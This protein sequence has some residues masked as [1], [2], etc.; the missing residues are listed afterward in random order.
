[1]RWI[2]CLITPLLALMATSSPADDGAVPL[3]KEGRA[4]ATVALPPEPTATLRTAAEEIVAYVAKISGVRLPIGGG[5][6][7]GPRIVLEVAPQT[8]PEEDAFR[9][10]TRPDEVRLLGG[11]EAGVLYAAYALLEDLGVRW[12]APGREG[13]VVPTRRSVAYPRTDR[14]ETPGFRC[15]FFYVESPETLLWAVRN[16]LNG[17]FPAKFAAAHG[18]SYYLPPVTPS[19]HSLA[20]LL[21]PEKY[22]A[23]HPEYYAL[24]GG[25]RAPC[26]E[27]HNQ[28]C[29]S[30]PQVIEIIA[31]AIRRHF[32]GTPG[33]R[34]Y[35][36]APN[37]GYGWCEC[38]RCTALD[39]KLCHSKKWW[40]SAEPVVSDRLCVFA[41]EVARRSVADMPGRE[42]VPVCLREL[43]RAA[44]DGPARPPRHAGHLPL[45]PRLLCTSDQYARLPR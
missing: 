16:R 44:G 15:R 6:R 32:Q 11:G 39:A 25:K 26:T 14:T 8:L 37:D 18:N 30:N 33:A 7:G 42:A 3:V 36:I 10:V 17:F 27:S 40:Y 38:Q 43:L 9:I 21:P 31:K 5:Q 41:N 34:V 1:M 35:S 19:L 13:E 12:L 24:L 4:V 2:T 28:L 20:L 29:T 45:Y 22:F 23:A